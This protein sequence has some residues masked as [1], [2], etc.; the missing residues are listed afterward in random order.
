MDAIETATQ[1]EPK[2]PRGGMGTDERAMAATYGAKIMGES[3]TGRGSS[4]KI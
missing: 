4:G 3:G 2:I 1:T